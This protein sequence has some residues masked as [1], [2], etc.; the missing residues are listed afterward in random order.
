MEQLISA[1]A[2]SSRYHGFE[3]SK[4]TPFLQYQIAKIV[5]LRDPAPAPK[6]PD[7]NSTK[8]PR[9]TARNGPNFV[10]KDLY[11]ETFAKYYEFENPEKPGT[12]LKLNELVERGIV[13]ELWFLAYQRDAGAP[14][15]STEQKPVY[16]EQFQRVG[17][18]HRH[19]GNGG[20]PAEPWFGRSLRILFINAERG[21]GCA[22]ESL[23][24]SIE[25]TANSGVIPYF[26]KYF[27][28]Y[29]GF[30]W[31]VK[32]KFPFN[33]LYAA[34]GDGKHKA[35][36]PNATTMIVHHGGKDFTIKDFVAAGGSVHFP[37][38]GRSDYDMDN[39]QDV[40]STIE[41]FRR[42]DGPGGKDIAEKF[43]I[44]KFKGFSQLAGDCMGPWLVYWRQCM[45]GL[46]NKSLDD[47]HK[48]MKN[49]FVFL[50]Y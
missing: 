39:P 48:P 15:E 25:A 8:Y 22:M 11:N 9:S 28:E 21:I 43:S 1:L 33:S 27:N 14:F 10:Y 50:F 38:N 23:G 5:D 3:I 47:A 36:Y 20:D 18:E 40:M 19:S 7:G 4:A 34:Q 17:D 13:N 30:D 24:H 31:N 37:P 32:Y 16:N 44:A 12:F 46:N 26:T 29:A 41:H 49:W 6:T 45:P 42:F 2:E 35:D